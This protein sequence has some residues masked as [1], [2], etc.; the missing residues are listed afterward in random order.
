VD[1]PRSLVTKKIHVLVDDSESM[2]SDRVSVSDKE[3]ILRSL[4][5]RCP[6][7]GCSVKE[8]LLSDLEP[9]VKKGY[10]PISEGLAKLHFSSGADPWVLISDG[11]DAKPQGVLPAPVPNGVVMA[12]GPED[13]INYSVKA[14][15]SAN[16]AFEGKVT[17]VAV[18]IGRAGTDASETV[19]IQASIDALP[20]ASINVK[21][22][23]G[24]S[25][26]KAFLQ[27]PTLRRGQ[28][29][30]TI[31]VIGVASERILWDNTQNIPLEVLP[32]TVGILHVL[33]SPDWDGRFLRVS[34][35]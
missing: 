33:G 25:E 18:T 20:V 13:G 21:F 10:S 23:Q 4:K 2:L 19:Q 14:V 26:A 9:D 6:E 27:I 24:K 32:N 17:E 7:V 30:L 11:G 12:V 28:Y 15:G 35:K 8:T 16:L 22:D 1:L 5:D 34:E 3:A 31:S 29:L